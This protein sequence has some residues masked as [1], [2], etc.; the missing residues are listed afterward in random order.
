M[1]RTKWSNEEVAFLKENYGLMGID[2]LAK[3]LN[4][5]TL[6][7]IRLKASRLGLCKKINN[8]KKEVK[9]QWEDEDILLLIM[10]YI[11][12]GAKGCKLLGVEHSETDIIKKA[13]ELGL[14]DADK[15]SAKIKNINKENIKEAEWARWELNIVKHYY[16]KEGAK[17]C[18]NR[19]LCRDV[20][21]INNKAKELGII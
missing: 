20:N 15:G 7:S 18:I 8:T 3:S 4:G 9:K 5:K 1:V 17:G 16:K 10:Y 19:C 21:S 14:E 11:K 6:N 2:K 13:I 12:K